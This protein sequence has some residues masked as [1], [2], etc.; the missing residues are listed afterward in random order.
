MPD[1]TLTRRPADALEEARLKH[2]DWLGYFL[3]SSIRI[4]GTGYRVGYDAVIGL[5]PGVGDL[6]GL[7]LSAY[8]VLAAA[9]YRLPAT[10]LLRMMLNLGLEVV[11][12]AIPLLG[13]LFDAGFK[14]NL[15]NLA[16]LHAH[17]EARRQG[18]ARPSDRTFFVGVLLAL[19][20][21]LAL[22]G[23]LLFALLL[24]VQRLLGA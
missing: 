12:G 8:L 13:D 3:D 11:V 6:I 20:G 7:A 15:R 24:A 2:L 21:V 17:L 22:A 10:T 14:A 1:S 23:L 4:P 5:V 9:R 19:G 18:L 16:L